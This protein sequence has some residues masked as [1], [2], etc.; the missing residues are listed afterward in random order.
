M[1]PGPESGPSLEAEIYEKTSEIEWRRKST[2]PG[3]NIEEEEE[4][5]EEEDEGEGG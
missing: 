3:Q 1:A 2:K 5:E 4:N